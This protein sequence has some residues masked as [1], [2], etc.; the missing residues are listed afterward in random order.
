M[1]T[2]EEKFE[3]GVALR[4]AGNESYIKGDYKQAMSQYYH[5]L[6][7]LRNVG[8]QEEKE[9]YDPLSSE[10]MIKIYNNMSAVHIK[11]ENWKRAEECANEVLKRDK[12]NAKA[13]FRLAQAYMRQGAIDKAKP[14]LDKASA[15]DPNDGMV[16]QELARYDKLTKSSEGKEKQVYRNM[17]QKMMKEDN[18]SSAA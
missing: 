5:A 2:P 13:T 12:D 11:N 7:Y 18:S 10:Q 14:L 6:L 3:K 4:V 9:K 8:G 15:A 17:L 1:S 16:K